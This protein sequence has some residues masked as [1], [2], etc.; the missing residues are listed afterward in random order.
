MLWWNWFCDIISFVSAKDSRKERC[1]T[2]SINFLLWWYTCWQAADILL[3]HSCL[4]LE[5]S[6]MHWELNL[7][8][9]EILVSLEVIPRINSVV[10]IRR[11]A[12]KMLILV[13]RIQDMFQIIT[14]ISCISADTVTRTFLLVHE[15]EDGIRWQFT[16][17]GVKQDKAYHL[18]FP[19]LFFMGDTMDI[20]NCACYMVVPKL[21]MFAT[22]AIVLEY[23]FWW[24][25]YNNDF[26]RQKR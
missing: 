2:D 26:G 11:E 3:N 14:D 18:C 20:T 19:I 8:L 23:T 6:S 17:D 5:Y 12:S 4:L 21:L 7:C 9:G 1:S 24:T 16:I 25:L 22:C 13:R 10:Q 15:L